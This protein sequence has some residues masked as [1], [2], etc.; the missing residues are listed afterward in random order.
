LISIDRSEAAKVELDY[1]Q[2]RSTTEENILI[3][4]LEN[5]TV[6][7]E[8]RTRN[9]L[10]NGKIRGADLENVTI[11]GYY[12]GL[13]SAINIHS[14]NVA[15]TDQMGDFINSFGKEIEPNDVNLTISTRLN[16]TV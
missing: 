1:T 2:A 16:T 12:E 10:R 15:N 6:K 13:S 8:P 11:C 5:D 4:L 3:C 9:R 7:T 14:S